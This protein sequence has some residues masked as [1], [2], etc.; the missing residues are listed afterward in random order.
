ML[1]ARMLR[2]SANVD[3]PGMGKVRSVV[4]EKP[5]FT[6]GLRAGVMSRGRPPAPLVFVL[7]GERKIMV[8]V[9]QM[10]PNGVAG[11]RRDGTGLRDNGRYESR[12]R[13]LTAYSRRSAAATPP[14]SD[15]SHL[16]DEVGQRIHSQRGFSKSLWA[17]RA[18]WGMELRRL[19][20]CVGPKSCSA[21]SALWAAQRKVR[22]DAT[23]APFFANGCR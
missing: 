20:M 11:G 5:L 18:W 17:A 4:P 1:Q 6:W 19:A 23:L 22:F 15:S 3:C 10:G 12:R 13:G 21:A 7:R 9:S 16:G 14:A 2:P 8:G